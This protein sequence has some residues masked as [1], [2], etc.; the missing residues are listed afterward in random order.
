MA[1]QGPDHNARCSALQTDNLYRRYAAWLRTALRRRFGPALRGDA[2]DLVQEAYVRLQTY[3]LTSEVRH[4]QAFLMQVANRL[5]LS[6]V[7]TLSRQALGSQLQ[8][9]QTLETDEHAT[10]PE[11][12]ESVLLRQLISAL[13]DPQR[14]VF[15]LSRFAGLTNQDIAQRLGISVKTVEWRMARALKALAAALADTEG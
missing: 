5:A 1:K 8:V 7:R 13:P 9:E 3:S 6:Q 12:D 15:V 2:E 11:Q 10:L 4:P 14:D